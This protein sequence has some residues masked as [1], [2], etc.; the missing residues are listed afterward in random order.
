MSKEL[1]DRV[2]SG[3]LFDFMGWL[4][5]REERL[6]LSAKDDAAPAVAVISEFLKKRGVDPDCEPMI[7]DWQLLSLDDTSL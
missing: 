3:V 1:L 2:V 4:T 5:S 6:I 7:K